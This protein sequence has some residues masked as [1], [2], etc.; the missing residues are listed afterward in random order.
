MCMSTI[1]ESLM[2]LPLQQHQVDQPLLLRRGGGV[3]T[4]RMELDS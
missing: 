1:S 3:N 4:L 2:I